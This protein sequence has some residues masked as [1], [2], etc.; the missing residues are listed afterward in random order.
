MVHK[1][2][3]F[4]EML[5]HPGETLK[6][7]LQAEWMTQEHLS[8]RTDI[9]T[10]H[11]SNMIN[12][13]ASITIDTALKLEKV[14]GMSAEFWINL[15]KSYDQDKAR[16]EEKQMM[17][18]KV[19]EE[20]QI[21]DQMK[22]G[23][24]DLEELWCFEKIRFNVKNKEIILNNLYIFFWVSS[25]K[26]I[27]ELFNIPKMGLNFKKTE[28][29]KLNEYSLACWMRAWE[30]RIENMQ[31]GEYSIVRLRELLP[32][33]KSM[34]TEDS[35]D[36][37]K[38][39]ELLA[40]AG[41]Y[42]SFAPWFKNVPVFGIT[43]KYKWKPY[44][45]ISDRLQKH[46]TFWFSLLH[47]LAHVQLHMIKKD[48]TLVNIDNREEEKEQEANDWAFNYL[49]DWEEFNLLIQSIP[50]S[51]KDMQDFSI[52]QWIWLSNLAWLLAH[53]FQSKWYKDAYREVSQIRLP[54]HI[55]N[56]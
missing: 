52:R 7:I 27:K 36:I 11:I 23:Y 54:L 51:K 5:I 13:K 17:L 6:D 32:E 29:L 33:L 8:L 24:K 42:F 30:K 35:V 1:R 14:F 25:L 41:V 48:E 50:L 18:L 47:E 44:I 26:N 19:E 34:T 55:I 49:V 12:S 38:I 39:Q 15:Q 9:T 16:A 2:T 4:P 46:D 43:R 22:D 45:Q 20:K 53:Y 3:F 56:W 40:P 31:V 21:L 10:K 37:K 28:S